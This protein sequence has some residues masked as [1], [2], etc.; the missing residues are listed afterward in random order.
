MPLCLLIPSHPLA[1]LCLLMPLC[2]LVP[3]CTQSCHC[4]HLVAAHT[5]DLTRILSPTCTLMSARS[6]ATW[7]NFHFLIILYFEFL[8]DYLWCEAHF[9]VKLFRL[10]AS[11]KLMVLRGR[12]LMEL[13]ARRRVDSR[14]I[15]G[16][17]ESAN[18]SIPA[19]T[20]TF[21]RF[22]WGK[23][24]DFM[25]IRWPISWFVYQWHHFTSSFYVPAREA[26]S[27]RHFY[28]ITDQS[29]T[30]LCNIWFHEASRKAS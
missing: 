30:Y 24:Q 7:W 8:L 20:E 15:A 21:Q 1:P 23:N 28:T 18:S 4:T 6:C 3:T 19:C 10:V 29:I 26:T 22:W 11:C 27:Q 16:S 12:L 5:P 9:F 14:F 2:S 17:L 25:I 13:M